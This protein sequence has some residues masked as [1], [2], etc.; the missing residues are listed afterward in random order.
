MAI[1]LIVIQQVDLL[2]LNFTMEAAVD[3]LMNMSR[4]KTEFT[5]REHEILQLVSIGLNNK[6]I[7]IHLSISTETVKRH[8]SNIY[9]KL[10]VNN[11][12]AALIKTGYL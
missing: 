12:I 9:N 4:L 2:L 5:A 8:L 7:A 10:E 1:V 11:K 3:K 6:Q